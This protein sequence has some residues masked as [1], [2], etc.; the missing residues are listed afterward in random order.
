MPDLIL[1]LICVWEDLSVS[2][3][4]KKRNKTGTFRGEMS[5]EESTVAVTRRKAWSA[6]SVPG[7]D[8]RKP[9]TFPCATAMCSFPLS[10]RAGL[11]RRDCF[12]SLREFWAMSPP[13][14]PLMRDFT[15]LL[16]DTTC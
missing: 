11:C 10:L 4:G 13:H 5:P 16:K 3:P 8:D 1:L 7:P 2:I 6:K 12:G 15:V 14:F 9:P